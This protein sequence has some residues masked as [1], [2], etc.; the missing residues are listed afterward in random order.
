[1]L[2]SGTTRKKAVAWIFGGD[3]SFRTGIHLAELH[4]IAADFLAEQL[5]IRVELGAA[6]ND[7]PKLRPNLRNVFLP[8]IRLSR[9]KS[10]SI[11]EGT[12]LKAVIGSRALNSVK[13]V[14]FSSQSVSRLRESGGNM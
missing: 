9:S 8:V 14:S 4:G 11:Q 7:Q 2:W 1:M 12:P 10:A 3:E 5:A 13:R 6:V